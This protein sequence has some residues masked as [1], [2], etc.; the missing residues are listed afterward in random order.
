MILKVTD[1]EEPIIRLQDLPVSVRGF[2]YHDDD[3][4][5]YIILNA[6]LTREM[7]ASSYL[8]ELRHISR[9][10]MYNPDY[11]EYKGRRN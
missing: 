11:L 4:R 9:G 6:R 2:C 10:D 8:H 3:G 7:N 5:A 1:P